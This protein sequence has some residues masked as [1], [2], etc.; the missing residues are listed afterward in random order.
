MTIYICDTVTDTIEYLISGHKGA[1]TAIAWNQ[2]DEQIIASATNEKLLYIW[3][4]EP[5]KMLMSFTL[6][7]NALSIQWNPL[8]R[9]AA[10]LLLES[11]NTLTQLLGQVYHM[12]ISTKK[13]NLIMT[14]AKIK[15]TILRIHPK[16]DS[17]FAV[18]GSQG[19]I[20]FY[21]IK[22]KKTV[23]ANNPDNLSIEDAQWHPAENYLIA[24]YCDGSIK[25]FEGFK[26]TET[27]VFDKEGAAVRT[28]N[29][30]KDTSGDFITSS[31]KAGV[32][33]LWNASQKTPKKSIK[34]GLQGIQTFE[35]FN[36]TPNHYI[37][38]FKDGSLGLFNMK[39]KKVVWNINAG[40]SESIFDVKFKPSN[41]EI[42]ATGSYDGY[43]KIWNVTNMKL[44]QSLSIK[45]IPSLAIEEA[46]ARMVHSISWSPNDSRIIAAYGNGEVIIWDYLK[47]KT[48]SRLQIEENPIISID[49]N[50]LDTNY[51]AC[52]SDK[53]YW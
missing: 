23:T 7:A 46:K 21:S 9:D 12:S 18:C 34:V 5:E 42:L 14:C 11:G 29:W 28:I 24:S 13:V 48:L 36:N 50:L 25:L 22:D 2:F 51:I 52:S 30:V 53:D 3:K 19:A 33:K 26:E 40:H 4:I 45:S 41:S 16:D 31:P 6:P 17:K 27:L 20:L 47:I 39:K 44:I 35:G 10:L 37:I 49:W 43:V 1:I 8:D 38:I 15:P 32:L